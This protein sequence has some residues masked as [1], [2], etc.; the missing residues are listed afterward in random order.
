MRAYLDAKYDAALAEFKTALIAAY[1]EGD[2]QAQI[3]DR[4]RAIIHLYLG[5]CY[6]H[7]EEWSAAFTEY[8]NAVQIDQ[9]LAEGHYNLGVAFRAHGRLPEA[10]AAFKSAL[11]HNAD[12]YEARFALGR[13]YH[14]LGDYAHAYI[15]Y[16]VA[17]QYRPNAAEPIYYQ[18]LLH[19]AHGEEKQAAKCFAEA[20]LVEPGYKFNV[21][22]AGTNPEAALDE[23]PVQ[24]AAWYYRLADELKA[25]GN[26]VGAVRAYQALLEIDPTEVRARYLMANILARQRDWLHAIGEY[27]KVLEQRPDYVQA[28]HKL[29][30]ALRALQRLR[31]AYQTLMDCARS[32]PYDGSIFLSLG[33]V[34][35]D[36]G[37]VRYAVQAFARA[38]QLLPDDPQAH[39]RLG[40]ALISLGYERR[41]LVAWQRAV[42]LDVKWQ[43]ARYDLGVLYLKQ[44]HYAR[45]VE[46]F[47]AVLQSAPDDLDAAYFLAIAY[48]E[49]GRLEETVQL[50]ERVTLGK[51]DHF[52]AHFHLGA[53]LLRLGLSQRGLHHLREYE[54]LKRSQPAPVV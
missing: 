12:L 40:R 38:V 42:E 13:C 51:P 35:T 5:N 26:M 37:Q 9:R 33:I 52:M 3:W 32:Q 20:L 14:E 17:R 23:N 1:V 36:L 10:I 30:L 34:L 50:L 4:E 21:L 15:A 45:A 22:V 29:G 44:E 16:T 11:G 25:R 53:T 47:E 6:A 54:R 49:I 27:T 2:D 43:A 7:L 28:R 24:D 8:M 19:Q 41:A 46:H 39:Y 48:K 18:G 31:E